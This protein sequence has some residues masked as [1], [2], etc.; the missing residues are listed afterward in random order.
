MDENYLAHYG[1]KG[2]KW[3]VVRSVNK[4]LQAFGRRQARSKA[5]Q[6]GLKVGIKIQKKKLAK[7]S[8]NNVKPHEDYAKAHSKK[9][10]KEMSD[11]ELR[12]RLNRI[13]MEQQYNRLNPS[14]V[15][16][17]KNAVNKTIKVMGTVGTATGA[18]LTAYNNSAKIRKILAGSS[19]KTIKYPKF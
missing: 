19:E 16:K 5:G 9:S 6:L 18:F 10:V 3:G 12:D 13:N 1:V 14:N 17:G 4:G 8:R 7:Q 15:S 2:M 11:K